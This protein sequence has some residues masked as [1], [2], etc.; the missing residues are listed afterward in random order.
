M[1]RYGVYALVGATTTKISDALD[2]IFP[3]I[4]F[5]FA[6]TSCQVLIYNILLA[7]WSVTYNE[8]GTLRK[9]QLLFFDRKW[10]VTDMG[11]VTHINSSPLSGLIGAYGLRE[12]GRVYKLY[13]DQS[14]AISSLVRTALWALNDPIRTKQALKIGVEATISNTGVGQISFTVDSENQSSSQITLTN[15]IQW[16]NNVLQVLQWQNNSGTIITWT[17]T[18]YALYKYDAQQYG[19]YLGMTITSTSPSFVYNGFQLEHELRVRF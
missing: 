4:D 3:N 6:V 1:N 5:S 7:A 8:S 9:L 13:N 16:I 11:E 18:G 15:G 14:A 19:K 10:F 12:S 2:N 17:P